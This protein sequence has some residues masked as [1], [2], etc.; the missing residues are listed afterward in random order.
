MNPPLKDQLKNFQ[1]HQESTPKKK[2]HEKL[3]E[4]DIKEL[5]GMNRATYRRHKGAFRQRG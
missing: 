5:M 2:Q 3:S 1:L 4:S